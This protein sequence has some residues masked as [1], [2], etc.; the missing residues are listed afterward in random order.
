MPVQLGGQPQADFTQPL[1]LLMDCHRRIENFLGILQKVVDRFGSNELNDEARRALAAA[2]AYFA[3]AAPN[4]TADEED[5]LF[6][7]LQQMPDDDLAYI[8]EQAKALERDHRN[9]EVIHERVDRL[10]RIWLS[11]GRLDPPQ[12]A[13]M[14]EDI[15]SLQEMYRSHIAF[16]DEQF[17]PAAATMLDHASLADIGREMAQRRG[18]P[19]DAGAIPR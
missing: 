7:R 1:Q 9:A 19:I 17:F 16:E 13:A 12:V 4:H 6:P 2:L 14:H 15:C 10:G 5:S 8:I 3:N 11:Q 18:L